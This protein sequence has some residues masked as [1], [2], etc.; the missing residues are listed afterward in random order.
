MKTRLVAAHG[1]SGKKYHEGFLKD[2][3]MQGTGE[4]LDHTYIHYQGSRGGTAYFELLPNTCAP[5]ASRACAIDGVTAA[6][7]PS[8]IPLKSTI[9]ISGVGERAALDTGG[10]I[11]GYHIDLFYGTRRH[12][13]LQL[14]RS[15][16]HAVT[17]QS[18]GN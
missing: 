12:A 7:D 8:V 18:Y 17:L 13:C 11:K 16:G 1:I 4:A 2:T 6:V 10:G 14:G 15:H 9:G 3:E 5:T